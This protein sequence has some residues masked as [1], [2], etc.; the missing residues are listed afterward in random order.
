MSNQ[1]VEFQASNRSPKSY[2]NETKNIAKNYGK[3]ILTFIRKNNKKVRNVLNL[4]E[5]SYKDFTC[6]IKREKK[7]LNTIEK[8]RNLWTNE[9]FGK[10]MRIISNLFLRRSSLKH[11][12]NSRIVN[13]E[14]HLKHR[15]SLSKALR[16]PYEFTC[17]K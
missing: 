8:L 11:I 14:C 3:A 2:K 9:T 17:I 13:Y 15:S 5:I 1:N 16:N 7:T 4:C 6:M 10:C 12:F